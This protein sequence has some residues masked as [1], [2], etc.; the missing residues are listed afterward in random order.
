MTRSTIDNTR[1]RKKGRENVAIRMINGNNQRKWRLDIEKKIML[2]KKIQE[3]SNRKQG[4][5]G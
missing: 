1:G 2:N 4:K 3:K 5:I